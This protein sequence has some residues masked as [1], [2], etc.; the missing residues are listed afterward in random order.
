LTSLPTRFSKPIDRPR[1]GRSAS[2]S[3]TRPLRDANADP[4]LECFDFVN[5]PFAA[6]PRVSSGS[7]E[8]S[9]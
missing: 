1:P 4:M 8:T 6:P 3:R 5:P 7:S 9:G 2:R